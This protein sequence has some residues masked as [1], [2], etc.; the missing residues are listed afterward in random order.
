MTDNERTGQTLPENATNSEFSKCQ[1]FDLRWISTECRTPSK[2]LWG[3]VHALK[4]V[5]I[6]DFKI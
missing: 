4:I 6:I 1:E 2:A 5:F 3:K